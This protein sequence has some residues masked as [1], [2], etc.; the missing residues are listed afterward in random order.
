M[1]LL[2]YKYVSQ[3]QYYTYR[4]QVRSDTSE[5][6][7]PGGRLLQQYIVDAFSSM[8]GVKAIVDKE[9][10]EILARRALSWIG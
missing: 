2:T 9:Q 5:I 7:L 4:L 1:R 10:S 8:E 3:K 6:L